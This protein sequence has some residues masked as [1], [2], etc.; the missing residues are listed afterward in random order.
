[1]LRILQILL[2]HPIILRPYMQIRRNLQQAR[3]LDPIRP[4]HSP[5]RRNRPLNLP[6]R[7]AHPT[8][9]QH[10]HRPISTH[11][12]QDIKLHIGTIPTQL[13]LDLLIGLYFVQW[14]DVGLADYVE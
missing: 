4:L 9:P 1:M 13:L 6:N 12:G 11:I 2:R 5:Y 7:L 10:H 8:L 3:N 14:V